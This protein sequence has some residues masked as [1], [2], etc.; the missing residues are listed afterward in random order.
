MVNCFK[1]LTLLRIVK[2]QNCVFYFSSSVARA[3]NKNDVSLVV[4][5]ELDGRSSLTSK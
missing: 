2:A 1:L 5:V 3:S 4:S